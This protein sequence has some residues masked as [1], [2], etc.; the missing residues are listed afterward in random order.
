MTMRPNPSFGPKVLVQ[1]IAALL[2]VLAPRLVLAQTGF[3]DVRTLCRPVSI[4]GDKP[5]EMPCLQ[6]LRDVTERAEGVLT[7]RLDNGKTKV[8][9]SNTEACQQGPDGCVEYRLVGYIESDRQFV[10]QVLHYESGFVLMVSRRNGDVTK[11]ED[12]PHLSPNN[13]RFV[14]VAAS[15]AGEIDNAIA[16]FSAVTDPP[17]LLWKFPTPHEYEQYAFDGWDGEGRILLRVITMNDVATD[18]KLTS[19]GWQLRRPNGEYDPSPN[20]ARLRRRRPRD[21]S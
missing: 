17:R 13:K 4:Q 18:L 14:V 16:I 21:D 5:V 11:L 7:L 1:G 2:L 19:Q 20:R 12:W 6:Q 9:K 3:P 15:D 10:L 8:F